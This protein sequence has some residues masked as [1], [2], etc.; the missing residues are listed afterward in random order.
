MASA[1]ARDLQNI[2]D[3]GLP[4]LLAISE[5]DSDERPARD[6][7]WSRKEELGHLID[8]ASNNHLRIVRAALESEF[9]GPGYQQAE[10]VALH[11]YHS[12]PWSWLVDFWHRYNTLL[13][14]LVSRVPE[15]RMYASCIIGTHP[16][17]RLD[18]LIDEYVVHMRHHLDHIFRRDGA[19]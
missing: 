17:M 6:G 14:Q 16:P 12:L 19:R 15:E 9:R 18:V 5:S 2:L 7:A 13:V 10:S 11:G 1:H 4:T 8:S 3:S